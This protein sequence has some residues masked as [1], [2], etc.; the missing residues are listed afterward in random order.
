MTCTLRHFVGMKC[1][2][3]RTSTQTNDSALAESA[4][5]GRQ[6]GSDLVLRWES[7]YSVYCL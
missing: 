4:Y 5:D 6:G 2:C 3:N 1:S 7:V